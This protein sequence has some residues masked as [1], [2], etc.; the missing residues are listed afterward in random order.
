MIINKLKQKVNMVAYLVLPAFILLAAC[1]KEEVSYETEIDDVGSA[2]KTELV[3]PESCTYEFTAESDDISVT[4]NTENIILPG[5]DELLTVYYEKNLY[6]SEYKKK[7][8]E[9]IFD[10]EDGIYVFDG[11]SLPTDV[12]EELDD[13]YNE[14]IEVAGEEG[15]SDALST[16]E[17]LLLDIEKQY[18]NANEPE[19]AGDYS[20]S[21]FFGYIDGRSYLLSFDIEGG[22]FNLSVYPEEF[23]VDMITAEDKTY[24]YLWTS[25]GDAAEQDLINTDALNTAEMSAEDA[26]YEAYE[27]LEALGITDIAEIETAVNEW[28]CYDLIFGQETPENV[29]DG[30]YVTFTDEINNVTPYVGYYD[31]VMSLSTDGEYKEGKTVPTYEV[32]LNDNGIISA[33]CHDKYIKSSEHVEQPDLLSWDEMLKTAEPYIEAYYG[34]KD[35]YSDICFNYVYLSYYETETDDKYELKPVWIFLEINDQ[36]LT[37]DITMYPEEMLIIDAATGEPVEI[38][39]SNYEE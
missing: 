19:P 15:D 28:V 14:C 35:V 20:A 27:F 8:A 9:G 31:L 13:Y 25:F 32:S 17:E 39:A 23:A 37:Y 22:G 1:G 6:D 18:E 29:Y 2:L 7:I 33:V 24:A 3:V 11:D 34:D 10:R 4:L 16:Y 12:L 26:Y 36:S 5:A 38:S 21:E 30:Y